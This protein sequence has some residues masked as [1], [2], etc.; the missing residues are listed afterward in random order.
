MKFSQSSFVYFHYPLEV[1][2]RHLHKFGYHG[3]EI[4]GG[5]PHVYRHDL[6]DQLDGIRTLLHRLG[7]AVCNFIPAQF[8]YP[9]ILCSLNETVRRESVQYIQGAIDNARKEHPP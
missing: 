9:S 1:A 7:M 8:R 4:W 6:D 3:I 5:R 2:I